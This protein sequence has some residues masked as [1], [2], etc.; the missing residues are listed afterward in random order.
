LRNGPGKGI[1]AI[2]V[3]PTSALANSQ[4]GELEKFICRGY[5]EGNRP[6]AFKRYTGQENDEENQA[7]IAHPP[8]ILL[9]N[10]VMLEL[11]LT[12]PQEQPLIRSAQGPRYLV[13]DELHTYRAR[14]GAD[15]ALLVRRTRDTLNAPELQCIGTSATSRSAP[16]TTAEYTRGCPPRPARL[17]GSPCRGSRIAGLRW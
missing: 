15:V 8:D 6:V 5:P 7:I 17:G 3:Y 13:P 1:R 9:T 10:Y 12:R 4:A 11:I 16:T 2:V 14:Q